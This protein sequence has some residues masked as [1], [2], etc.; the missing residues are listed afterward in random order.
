ML[1]ATIVFLLVLAIL[2]LA[3][4]PTF[5]VFNFSGARAGTNI[6]ASWIIR[7]GVE[8]PYLSAWRLV[9]RN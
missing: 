4:L 5:N 8:V 6:T 1:A 2:N 9:Y 3:I 7:I